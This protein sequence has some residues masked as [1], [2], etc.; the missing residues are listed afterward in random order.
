MKIDEL[1][2]EIIPPEKQKKF[3]ILCAFSWM[4][5]A[6]GV[7]LMPFTLRSIMIEW[8]LS[9]M[10]ASTLASSTFVGMLIG[11][12]ISGF[13]ADLMGRKYANLLFIFLTSI[14]TAFNGLADS[15]R[16]FAI[17]RFISGIGYGGLL[18]SINAYLSE[19]TSIRLRG[20]YLVYL[21]TSWA[22]GSILIGL[23]AVTVGAKLGWRADYLVMALFGFLMIPMALAPE[24][25]KYLFLKKGITA[26]EKQFGIKIKHEIEPVEKVSV[27]LTALFRRQYLKSTIMVWISW[28]TISF[29]YYGIF[30]WLPG[31]F[32]A[33]GLG[34]IKSMWFT[35]LMMVAQLPG[36]LSVAYLIDRIGRRLTLA[37]YFI[38]TAVSVFIFAWATNMAIFLI[39]ALA[40][41]FFCLGVWG[42]VY[43]YTP[44]LFPTSFRATANGMAGVMARI[45]GIVA[46]YFT[47]YFLQRANP[48]EALMW[49]AMLSLISGAV[50]L[51][52]GTETKGKA[53]G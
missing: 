47:G 10:E 26:I 17:L 44:E 16:T 8:N 11:A 35:F 48:M 21:E 18:P 42:V 2:P 23:F 7:M 24:S 45:A 13:I 36:Y 34:D 40:T 49:F 5:V 6:A 46:P 4:A 12:F 30:V 52:L 32:A 22:I 51:L 19:L 50:V 25:P 15:P 3:L 31:V 41:S 53:V 14:I 28:F 9:K 33:R 29:V 20:R 38:G 43:A 37:I 1:I 39:A 27:P